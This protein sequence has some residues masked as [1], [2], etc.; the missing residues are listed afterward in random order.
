[1]GHE[2]VHTL[3]RSADRYH[4]TAPS[5]AEL[6]ETLHQ[7]KIAAAPLNALLTAEERTAAAARKS[8]RS[9]GGSSQQ[10]RVGVGSQ[11]AMFKTGN[12]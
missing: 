2:L 9:S 7:V 1:V 12:L 5:D 11:R 8:S 4:K 3:T 10:L 6:A